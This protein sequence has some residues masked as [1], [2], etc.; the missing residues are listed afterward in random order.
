MKTARAITAAAIVRKTVFLE[1]LFI[2]PPPNNLKLINGFLLMA[3]NMNI[4]MICQQDI[5]RMNRKIIGMSFP[6]F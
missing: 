2:T 6:V 4:A 3:K 1:N 5:Q